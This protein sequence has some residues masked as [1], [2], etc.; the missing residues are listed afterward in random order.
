M[1]G[2]M[3]EDPTPMAP[4]WPG[5]DLPAAEPLPPGATVDTQ[6]ELAERW[7]PDGA[8]QTIGTIAKAEQFLSANNI[9]KP[10]GINFQSLA[11]NVATFA[12]IG[13]FFGPGLGTAIGAAAGLVYSVVSW[14]IGGGGASDPPP[15]LEA[16]NE[17]PE[18]VQYWLIAN[19]Q[20]DFVN[21]AVENG[22]NGL[23]TIRDV[24]QLQL[25]YWLNRYGYLLCWS[26]ARHYNNIRDAVHIDAAGGEQAVA[27]MYRHNMADYWETKAARDAAG[28]LN[29]NS[30][31]SINAILKARVTLPDQ[32]QQSTGGSSALVVVGVAAAAALM[33]ANS[34]Q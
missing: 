18:E 3:G 25:I 14:L 33:M 2:A 12:G 23:P 29:V 5:T 10:T 1:M 28:V 17:S 21:W 7:T 24:A 4:R 26:N 22:Y 9:I 20:I 27:D 6:V 19:G 16:F 34:K 8:L 13:T 11:T 31:Y 32:D 15:P 30:G